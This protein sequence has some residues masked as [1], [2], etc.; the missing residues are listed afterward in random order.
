MLKS[1]YTVADPQLCS[2]LPV[3][4][5]TVTVEFIGLRS[6]EQDWKDPA[7]TV[8]GIQAK[9]DHLSAIREELGVGANDVHNVHSSIMEKF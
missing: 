4:F 2:R 9:V 3:L 5:P 7:R 6:H 8:L 1:E